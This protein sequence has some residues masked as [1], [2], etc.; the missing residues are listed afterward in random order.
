MTERPCGGYDTCLLGVRCL[1]RVKPAT[2]SPE[3]QREKVPAAAV[4][5]HIIGRADDREVSGATDSIGAPE[6]GPLAP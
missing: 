3:R 2:S 5:A 4:S 1:S 6:A